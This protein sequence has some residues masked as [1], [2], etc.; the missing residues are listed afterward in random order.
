MIQERK[1]G[2]IDKVSKVFDPAEKIANEGALEQKIRNL[3]NATDSVLEQ[4]ETLLAQ[5]DIPGKKEEL[6]ALVTT[7]KSTG[8]KVAAKMVG[9]TLA[10]ATA[11]ADPT[12]GR[13]A[14][15]HE[16]TDIDLSGGIAS[17]PGTGGEGS[18]LTSELGGMV[19]P[20][21]IGVFCSY[22]S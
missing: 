9:D 4:I 8:Q 14:E 6:F 20:V 7:G 17:A 11:G 19:V 3:Q 16:E 2:I 18:G 13:G 10:T 1:N 15:E 22:T 12:P 21:T 5:P